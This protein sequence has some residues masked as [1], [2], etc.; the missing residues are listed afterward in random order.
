M[1]LEFPYDIREPGDEERT[2]AARASTIETQ[3]ATF[4]VS[5]AHPVFPPSSSACSSSTAPSD[6]AA[7]PSSA[8]KPTAFTSPRRLSPSFPR[9]Q[10]LSVSR[11]LA[12]AWLP[13]LDLDSSPAVREQF[14][15]VV[16]GRTVLA[17]EADPDADEAD[18]VRRMGFAPWSLC[19]A[20]HQFGSF[21]G[22]LGDGRAISIRAFAGSGFRRSLR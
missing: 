15:D 11:A 17:R 12:A 19:Y 10:L 16:A 8:A 14:L 5:P 4:E 22:Q 21:A 3:L 20:G 13:Q 18:G 9:A 7:A 1:P 6:V 2:N